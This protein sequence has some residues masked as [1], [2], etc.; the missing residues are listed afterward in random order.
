MLGRALLNFGDEQ[1]ARAYWDIVAREDEDGLYGRLARLEMKM[2][3]WEA[4]ELPV[5]LDATQ[6]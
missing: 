1:K 5:L 3:D 2:L 6:L 4:K